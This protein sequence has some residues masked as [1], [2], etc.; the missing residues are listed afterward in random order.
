MKFVD[1]SETQTVVDDVTLQSDNWLR[2]VATAL[3]YRVE[4]NAQPNPRSQL[5]GENVLT[6]NSQ[7]GPWLF[8]VL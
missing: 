8:F 3:G 2:Y 4:P 7:D 1:G 5:P 6:A